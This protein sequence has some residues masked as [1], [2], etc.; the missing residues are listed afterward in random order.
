MLK[1]EKKVIFQLIEKKIFQHKKTTK[2]HLKNLLKRDEVFHVRIFGFTAQTNFL[3]SSHLCFELLT[4][5]VYQYRVPTI[6]G[7][8]DSF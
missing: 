1:S 5:E 3:V 4:N 7:Y 2:K 6:N 8:V